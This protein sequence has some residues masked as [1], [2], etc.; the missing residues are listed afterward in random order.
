MRCV[1]MAEEVCCIVHAWIVEWRF[2]WFAYFVS[3]KVVK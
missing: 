2:E 3:E 1:P